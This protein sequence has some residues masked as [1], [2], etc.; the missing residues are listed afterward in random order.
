MEKPYATT[1]LR[2]GEGKAKAAPR[3]NAIAQRAEGKAP[4][5]RPDAAWEPLAPG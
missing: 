3:K 5:E 1:R 4:L 2:A